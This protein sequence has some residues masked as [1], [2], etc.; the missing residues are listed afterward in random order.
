MYDGG[1]GGGGGGTILQRRFFY[2]VLQRFDLINNEHASVRI[3]VKFLD[4]N[5]IFL[6][7]NVQ[8]YWDQEICSK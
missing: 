6:Q 7:G 1:S 4:L 2:N 3:C 5:C 8:S